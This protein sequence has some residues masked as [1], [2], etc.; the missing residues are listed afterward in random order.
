M[1]A[2]ILEPQYPART[3]TWTQ[4]SNAENTGSIVIPPPVVID[5]SHAIFPDPLDSETV[6]DKAKLVASSE[7]WD[8]DD[9]EFFD[10]L[11]EVTENPTS[12]FEYPSSNQLF[13]TTA[14]TEIHSALKMHIDNTI[15]S[16]STNSETSNTVSEVFSN[17][18]RCS[19]M[20]VYGSQWSVETVFTNVTPSSLNDFSS[21][22]SSRTESIKSQE[23]EMMEAPSDEDIFCKGV[24]WGFHG[25]DYVAPTAKVHHLR[26]TMRDDS[27]P[28]PT[29][30]G[31]FKTCIKRIFRKFRRFYK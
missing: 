24:P 8:S 23:E 6:D 9:K 15:P 7:G 13:P 4:E 20:S 26:D 30:C 19:S 31:H 27:I 28:K 25:R 1:P 18:S 10:A 11:E 16:T 22:V 29:V 3:W 5:E 17:A 14:A 12:E 2:N 21:V